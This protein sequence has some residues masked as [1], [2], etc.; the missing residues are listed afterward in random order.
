MT[1]R[2]LTAASDQQDDRFGADQRIGY[3][4]R[5]VV[6]YCFNPLKQWRGITTRVD[7]TTFAYNAAITVPPILIWITNGLDNAL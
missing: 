5:N 7:N 1:S 6:G 2:P 4:P 3:R